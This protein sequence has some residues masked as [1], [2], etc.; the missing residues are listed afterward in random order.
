MSYIEAKQRLE[1]AVRDNYLKAVTGLSG[2]QMLVSRDPDANELPRVHV[3][4]TGLTVTEGF[5]STAACEFTA[6]LAI[7]TMTT[8]DDKEF[9]RGAAISATIEEAMSDLDA[10]L[11]AVN[12]DNLSRTINGI[13][14]YTANLEAMEEE[15]ID[16][17]HQF[18]LLF[19]IP[20]MIYADDENGD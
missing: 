12:V 19:S 10:F 17:T 16:R 3:V 4:A 20:F 18:V 1:K 9:D 5:E 8:V 2:V 11:A 7:A 13:H 6:Q 15:V 14:V